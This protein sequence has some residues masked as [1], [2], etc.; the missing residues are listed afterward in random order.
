M[1]AVLFALIFCSVSFSQQLGLRESVMYAL[2]NNPEIRAYMAQVR[3][4]AGSAK[5]VSSEFFPTLSW[6]FDYTRSGGSGISPW[7]L[8][9]YSFVA[10]WEVFS[11]FETLNRWRAERILIEAA[12]GNLR[13]V[14]LDVAL[15]VVRFYSEALAARYRV[16]AAEH[17]VKSAEYSYRLALA[18]Y[19]AGLAPWADVLYARS[20]LKE[21]RYK[22]ADSKRDYGVAKGNLASV[23]GMDP[24]KV[25][26]VELREVSPVLADFS[27]RS[28]E[29]KAVELSPEIRAEKK[30]IDAQKKRIASVKG[31]Y[32]PKV[33]LY[34]QWK[35]ED[36]SLFPDDRSL[37][38]LGVRVKLPIFT[39]FS[40]L[41]KIRVERARLLSFTSDL[42]K[43]EL[44]VKRRLWEAYQDYLKAKERLVASKEY[45]EASKESYRIMEK[46]YR[47]G[48][49]SIVD[50]ASA[51]ADVYDAE[52]SYYKSLTDV[53]FH[54]YRLV[55]AVGRI[56][57]V[58]G[59]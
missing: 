42:R 4:Q 55:R 27:F 14:M 26:Q 37:W 3:M 15:D 31:E 53:V 57:V 16:V 52:S 1:L 47:V 50:L 24:G 21:A 30:R 46:K 51:Q 22:L 41:R 40:T 13:R 5:L 7:D 43:A 2:K 10:E 25:E 23:M 34:G 29:E 11:G 33:S 49:A 28:L 17:Y 39:G 32:M 20:K 9:S 56:P 59:L 38:S 35:R 58:E 8:Y 12:K 44:E 54:Y 19:R 36:E 48:L 45:W 6:E 18:R